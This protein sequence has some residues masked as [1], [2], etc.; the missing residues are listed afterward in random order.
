MKLLSLIPLVAV[1]LL[2][3]SCRTVIPVDPMT[4]K[5]S[6]RCVPCNVHPKTLDC[7]QEVVYSSK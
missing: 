6:C 7:C 2:S 4:G 1:V 3:N 5:Q